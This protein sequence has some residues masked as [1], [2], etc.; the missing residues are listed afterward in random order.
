M[1]TNKIL[2]PRWLL[3]LI[4]LLFFVL[5]M[6]NLSFSPEA[7]NS[8][9]HWF[10]RF[11][12]WLLFSHIRWQQEVPYWAWLPLLTLISTL[13]WG[14][15]FCGWI[16]PLGAFLMITDK[17]GRVVFKKMPLN[18]V[19]VL[20]A[21]QTFRWYWLLFVV[22]VFALGSNVIFF[23]TPFAFLSHEMVSWLQGNVPWM[24]IAATL[25]TMLF[26]RLWCSAL[27]PTGALL[28]LIARGR[29]FHYRVNEKCVRCGKCERSCPVGAVSRDND[30]P[31]SGCLVCG[32]C[33][34]VCPTKAID[35]QRR[36]DSKNSKQLL[37]DGDTAEKGRPVSRRE[38]FKLT[39][40]GAMAYAFWEMAGWAAEKVVRP[41]GALP[42]T[43]FNSVCN[44]CGRCIQVCPAK[45]LQPMPIT[46]GIAN[47]A[48]PYIVP[49]KGHCYFCMACQRVCPTGAIR[50]ILPARKM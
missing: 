18:R 16:C 20:Q 22:L 45:V 30:I 25:G 48:T 6:F 26:S 42:E 11:D 46:K 27:C 5:L 4:S 50:E 38:F 43:T 23:L 40:A 13:L 10:S 32:E 28:S 36:A 8:A 21:A 41:P 15:L 3:Q 35:W 34:N 19:K 49:D 12:P 9:L 44:R 14:R 47:F 1:K 37:V 2:L 24:L 31:E 7:G 33:R 17:I 29:L 39:F